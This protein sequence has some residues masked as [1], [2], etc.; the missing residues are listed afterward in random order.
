MDLLAAHGARTTL[1]HGIH[2]HGDGAFARAA[3]KIAVLEL[4]THH[5]RLTAGLLRQQGRFKRTRF[6]VLRASIQ[7]GR[8]R[9]KVFRLLAFGLKGVAL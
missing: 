2:Q 1:K 8:T 9:I 6:K 7:I 5:N 4:A 3:F